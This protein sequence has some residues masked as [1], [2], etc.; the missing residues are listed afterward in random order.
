[1]SSLEISR[2][3][4]ESRANGVKNRIRH[5]SKRTADL[6][7]GTKNH[8]STPSTNLHLLSRVGA[9]ISKGELTASQLTTD[10]RI[11]LARSGLASNLN[12]IDSSRQAV[13]N[14]AA[15]V[16]RAAIKIGEEDIQ[17][18]DLTVTAI[19][20][21]LGGSVGDAARHALETELAR[22]ASQAI[23][24]MMALAGVNYV[25]QG[26]YAAILQGGDPGVAPGDVDIAVD[27]PSAAWGAFDADGAFE[28]VTGSDAIRGVQKAKHIETEVEIDIVMGNPKYVEFGIHTGMAE[29]VAGM[30]VLDLF[31]TLQ[32]LFLRA[33]YGEA[34]RAKDRE[35]ARKMITERGDELDG[36]QQKQIIASAGK[37]G[38]KAETW[39]DLVKELNEENS[40]RAS[41]SETE[42]PP[43]PP[44]RRRGGGP[45]GKNSNDDDNNNNNQ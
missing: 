17:T 8:D 3:R 5:G 16:Q 37:A 35:S 22:R 15:P 34:M 7:G 11:Q 12:T 32:S 25:I 38:F 20:E 6:P 4:V 39:N 29:D 9:A 2:T 13:S 40:S 18:E 33:G 24:S 21:Y 10:V 41:S 36:V 42:K 1:M 19:R 31:N 27:D 44:P 23:H 28:M 26:S 30:K 14:A 43:Q 45:S